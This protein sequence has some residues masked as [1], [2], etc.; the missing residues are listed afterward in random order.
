VHIDLYVILAVALNESVKLILLVICSI[1]LGATSLALRPWTRLV[2]AD[3]ETMLSKVT[4]DLDGVPAHAWDLDTASKLLA[5]SC[6]IEQLGEAT[7]TK[8]DMSTFRLM[9]WT[10]NGPAQDRHKP[11][12]VKKATQQEAGKPVLPKRSERLANH[13]LAN[14]A[15]SKRAEVVLSGIASSLASHG[16][17]QTS[18][19]RTPS[20]PAWPRLGAALSV[21]RSLLRSP[22]V[23]FVPGYA[24]VV[25]MQRFDAVHASAPVNTDALKS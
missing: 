12:R 22:Q 6:W 8:D 25:L 7:R 13:P 20:S 24:L 15:S 9:A 16:G 11:A 4:I 17:R 21:L 14:V 5:G 2:H 1:P 23:E 19:R 18:R 10:T 3:S